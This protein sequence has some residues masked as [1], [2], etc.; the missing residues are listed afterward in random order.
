MRRAKAKKQS[1][2]EAIDGLDPKRR[3]LLLKQFGGGCKAYRAQ[4]LMHC[5]AWMA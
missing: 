1:V 2:M 3:Q 4:A 5:V